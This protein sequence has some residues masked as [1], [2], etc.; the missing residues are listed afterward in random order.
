QERFTQNLAKQFKHGG[1]RVAF[2]LNRKAHR[3][4]RRAASTAAAAAAASPPAATAAGVDGGFE[5]VELLAQLLMRELLR[6]SHH[7]LGEKAGRGF[8]AFEIFLVA[9]TQ[10]ECEMH[11]LASRFLR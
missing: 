11:F 4:C 7:Q 6:S 9:V 8:E 5:F 10:R 1:Q 3:T 2:G